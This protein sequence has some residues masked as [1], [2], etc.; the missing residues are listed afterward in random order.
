MW[1]LLRNRQIVGVKFRRQQSIGPFTV[2]FCSFEIKMVV[3]C[4][5]L[6]H[7]SADAIAYDESRDAYLRAQGFSVLRLSNYAIE[8]ET[9][10]ALQ[11]IKLTAQ[12]LIDGRIDLAKPSDTG[13]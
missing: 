7:R 3:E 6:V 11:K 5:G 10:A 1:R 12:Q 13:F 9:M 2:D 8:F 4:D